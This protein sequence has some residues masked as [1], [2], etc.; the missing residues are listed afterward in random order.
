MVCQPV[1]G[2]IDSPRNPD[3][4]M[5]HDMIKEFDQSGKPRWP[6]NQPAMQPDRQHL[7]CRRTFGIKNIKG[8]NQILGKLITRMKSLRSG[9]AHIICIQRIRNNQMRR[10]H[11]RR[12]E[13]QIIRII[14]RVINKP[15][16][17]ERQD[18]ACFPM[19]APYTNQAD[20]CHKYRLESKS[21]FAYGRV[22]HQAACHDN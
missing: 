1:I 7:W 10:F 20:A 15:A 11:L 9:K 19:F 4:V 3:L 8:V 18:C 21:P 17:F 13:W 2:N 22:L 16:V 14:I 6:P 12:P 5:R